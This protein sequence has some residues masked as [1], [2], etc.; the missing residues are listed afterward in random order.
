MYVYKYYMSIKINQQ[1]NLHLFALVSSRNKLL[2][3]HCVQK[4][5]I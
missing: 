3:V 4:I 1:L 2:P 5:T